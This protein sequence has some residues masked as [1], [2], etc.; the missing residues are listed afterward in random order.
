M[1]VIHLL[2]IEIQKCPHCGADPEIIVSTKAEF[3]FTIR[4]D[5]EDYHGRPAN[6]AERSLQSA[7]REW[8]KYCQFERQRQ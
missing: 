8:N 5:N 7:I 3:P 1:S 6:I 4:C 2:D